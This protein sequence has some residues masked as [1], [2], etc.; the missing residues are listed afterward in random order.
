M[1][2]FYTD[3]DLL[4]ELVKKFYLKHVGIKI[5]YYLTLVIFK[6]MNPFD[7]KKFDI[8]PEY[9]KRWILYVD[10][11][12]ITENHVLLFFLKISSFAMCRLHV[13]FYVAFEVY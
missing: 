12:N 8:F 10:H 11:V 5:R 13:D 2:C 3:I 7:Y 6:I 1:Q 9:F 4:S